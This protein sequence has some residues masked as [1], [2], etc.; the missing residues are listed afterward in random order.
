MALVELGRSGLRIE[1]NGFGALPIQ[2]VPVPEAVSLLQRALDGGMTF[3]DTARGY[4]DS[5]EKLGLAFAD[6]RSQIVLA[7]KTPAKQ[8]DV[9]WNHLETS[10]RVLRT[11]MIDLYQ[12]HNPAQYPRPDDGTGLY[13]AMCKAREQGKIR[14]IGITNHRLDVARAAVASGLYDTL[15]FPFSYLSDAREIDLVQACLDRGMGFIAMKALSGGLI[16]QATA[17]CAW[18]CQWGPVVPIWGIQRDQ[19]LSEF[20]RF[21]TSMPQLT[22]AEQAIIEADRQELNGSFCRGCGYCMPCPQG[23]NISMCARASLLLRRAPTAMLLGEQGRAMMD[24]VADCTLCGQC[25]ARCPY[26][27]DTPALLQRNYADYQAAQKTADP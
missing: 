15:Q 14:L 11:D 25:A 9:F 3:Y 27:L 23:I 6:R 8:V 13:E 18:L 16:T 22:D 1:Q 7:T 20:L 12:F 19:E 24:R 10:L 5:E 4:T 26:D 21:V 17:A 2:R